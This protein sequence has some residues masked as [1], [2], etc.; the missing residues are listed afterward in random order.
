MIVLI[1]ASGFIGHA[2]VIE[3]SCRNLNFRAL[4]RAT[5]TRFDRLYDFLEKNR[6]RIRFLINAAGLCGVPNVD[7]LEYRKADALLANVVLPVNIAGA[8]SILN[9]PW[10]QI[11][12]GCVFE[13]APPD[14]GGWREE[15][16]P[17]FT[18]RDNRH[19]FY[20]GCKALAEESIRGVGRSYVWRLRMPFSEV[21]HSKNLISKLLTY[22]KIFDSP[23][24]SL[25]HLGESVK[26]C[27]DLWECEA[28][29]GIWNV[30]NPGSVTNREIVEMIQ[31]I[32]KPAREFPFF[33][34][35]AAFYAQGAHTPRSNC[36]LSTAK[37]QAAG[38]TMRPV[39]E[40]LTDSLDNWKSALP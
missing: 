8:C 21:D 12:S 27:I 36:V 24:N 5:Y 40:A 23:A 30:V 1:G 34:S 6:A 35:K 37:L 4:S 33:Q 15:D 31:R 22:P 29:F 28:P 13:G 3:L 38:I 26:A 17:N 19:S 10:A 16:T 39:Q 7:E 11:S 18:F 25:S 2:F 20:T 14:A 9:I 32:L